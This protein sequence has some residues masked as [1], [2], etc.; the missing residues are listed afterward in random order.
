[1]DEERPRTSM[2]PPP[3][4]ARSTKPNVSV[5]TKPNSASPSPPPPPPGRVSSVFERAKAFGAGTSP[6]PVP[7]VPAPRSQRE[8]TIRHDTP[9]DID[10]I[11]WA[12]LSS[13]DKQVFFSWLDEFFA[14]FIEQK[15]GGGNGALK[16]EEHV[17]L[18]PAPPVSNATAKLSTNAKDGP[19]VRGLP[20]RILLLSSISALEIVS[21]DWFAAAGVKILVQTE[22]Q[23]HD[24][25]I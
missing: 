12:N 18:A 22:N 13:E 17:E 2:S 3:P 8:S 1:M 15:R 6:I 7:P 10:K 11:D 25:L 14:R 20:V 16:V 19:S 21:N 24:L 5:N 4:V 23:H 9:V